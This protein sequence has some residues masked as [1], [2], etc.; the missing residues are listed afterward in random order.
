[1]ACEDQRMP[2]LHINHLTDV[3]S[4]EVVI[5]TDYISSSAA[6]GAGAG[7]AECVRGSSRVV[8]GARRRQRLSGAKWRLNRSMD[9]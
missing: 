9:R 4:H 8:Q 1:M 3:S 7:A 5:T 6:A 2:V